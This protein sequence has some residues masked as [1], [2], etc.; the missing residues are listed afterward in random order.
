MMIDFRFRAPDLHI[1]HLITRQP[2]QKRFFMH[3]HT[4]AEL[5]CFLGGKATFHV[6]GTAYPL[7]PGDIL[8]MRPAESHYVQLD[9]GVPYERIIMNFD[10]GILTVLDPENRLGQLFFGHKAGKQNHYRP[11]DDRCL[12]YLQRMVTPATEQRLTILGNLI[13]LLLQLAQQAPETRSPGDDPDTLEYR[14]IR[15]INKNLDADLSLQA[16]CDRFFIS[17]TQLCQR[18]RQA[19]G[20]SVGNYIS[21]KRLILARQLLLQDQKPTEIFSLCGYKDYSSFY[22]AYTAYF[23]HSPREAQNIREDPAVY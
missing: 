2:S 1:S 4:Y 3:T 7:Q 14:L 5:Y 23:G 12:Q 18:F 15:Y 8:L 10:P 11:T 19:T 9:P 17:R 6:E 21:V 16:L 20:A 22:R 13:L